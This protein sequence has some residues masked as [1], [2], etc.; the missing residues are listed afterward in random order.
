LEFSPLEATR[1]TDYELTEG[2]KGEFES[3][4]GNL[5]ATYGYDK[6]RVYTLN[7]AN[8]AIAGGYTDILGNVIP[9][10]DAT[11]RDFLRW[12]FQSDPD[13]CEHRYQS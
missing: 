2:L 13:D 3:G 12:L 10:T 5:S 8:A 9:G 11:P 7:S 1:E 4:N 6:V